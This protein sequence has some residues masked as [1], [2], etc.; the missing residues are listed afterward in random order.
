MMSKIRQIIREEIAKLNE[1]PSFSQ[2]SRGAKLRDKDGRQLKD[3][4]YDSV[5]KNMTFYLMKKANL[6]KPANTFFVHF[7]KDEEWADKVQDGEYD[8]PMFPPS[9]G[10]A[11]NM[12]NGGVLDRVWKTTDKMRGGKEVVGM[13]EGEIYK[14][15]AVIL[16]MS[17]RPGLKRN[18]L[19][20]K[21]I[22]A[23]AKRTGKPIAFHAP[24]EEGFAFIRAKFP[25]A[26]VYSSDWKVIDVPAERKVAKKSNVASFDDKI[27]WGNAKDLASENPNYQSYEFIKKMPDE[28][29]VLI[30]FGIMDGFEFEIE[31]YFIN[32]QDVYGKEHIKQFDADN[33]PH[34]TRITSIPA[35]KKWLESHT[36]QD[37]INK[38]V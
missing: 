12:R 19:N 14:G 31:Y 27:R 1:M 6:F 30:E 8:Y 20:S 2:S 5:S 32:F 25:K 7:H 21:M 26:T 28:S 33:D 4:D 22:K 10:F 36:W 34:I 38:V 23:V 17:V 3:F 18:T 35:L 11:G 24:T 9:M 37:L 15:E 13:I 16:Y 29:S